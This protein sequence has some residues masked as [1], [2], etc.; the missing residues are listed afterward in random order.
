MT[1]TRGRLG[2][3]PWMRMCPNNQVIIGFDGRAGALVDSLTFRC[4][5][6]TITG[7]AG[8][9]QAVIG[10]KNSLPSIGG[11]GGSSFGVSDCPPGQIATKLIGRAGDSLDALGLQCSLITAN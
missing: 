7:T 9:Y 6:I 3:I 10:S 2:N 1:P 4:A 11:S 8:N 5:P